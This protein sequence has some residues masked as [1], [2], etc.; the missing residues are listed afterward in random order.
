MT[1]SVREPVPAD[2]AALAA[3]HVSTWRETYER[4]LPESFFSEDFVAGRRRMWDQ[5]L[6]APREDF[7][8]R[9]AERDGELVGFVW[10]GAAPGDAGAPRERQLYALYVAAAQHG[11]G[12]GQALLDAALGSDP[13]Q[14]WVAKANPRAIAFYRRNG[15]AF[16]GAEQT[17]AA[18]PSITE[19]RMRRG[20]VSAQVLHV[21]AAVIVDGGEV[22]ACRR[23]PGKPAGGRWE[24]PGGK[25]EV[26]ESAADALRREIREE[27]AVEIDVR[28]ELT[29]DNT[30]VGGRVIRLT[31]LRAVLMGPRPTASSDHDLLEW[32]SPDALPGREWAEPDLPAVRLLAASVAGE[33]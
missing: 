14:L 15:F 29:T 32:L 2:A 12:A 18:A 28:E 8:V 27:L 6:T 5:V 19:A 26:G 33:G 11:T 21:V 9:V 24:F 23:R 3:L 4:M 25:I 17:D 13:A 10:A 31:C 16:D 30:R 7:I 22:L 1:W 20:P